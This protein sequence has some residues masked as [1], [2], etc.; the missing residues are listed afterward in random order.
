MNKKAFTLLELLATL[1]VIALIAVITI[2]VITNL[3][4]G[5]KDSMYVRSEETL[6]KA[7]Q[8]YLA[9]NPELYPVLI[10]D[11]TTIELEDLLA[12]KAVNKILDPSTK[13]EC[14]GYVTIKKVSASKS[15]YKPYI[16]CG[17]NYATTGYGESEVLPVITI[18]GSNPLSHPVLT[19]Y[20]DAGATALDQYSNN[21]TGDI[22][23]VN[24]VNSNIVGTY[25]VDY[26]VTDAENNT[27]NVSR[28]VN[29]VD[30]INP[31]ITVLGT[32]PVTINAGG[33]YVD[34]GATA[35]DNYS[36]NLTS[37]IQVTTN[38]T[39]A[40]AG[41]YTT[42]YTVS[43][44]SGNIATATRT[45]NV[46]ESDP[47]VIIFGTNGNA[48]Y[49]QSRSSTITATD[50]S[51]I[52]NA[53]L[54]YQWTTS[55]TAPSEVSFVTPYTNGQSVSSPAGVT[56]TYYLWAIAKDTGG[57]TTISRTNSFNLDN[58]IPVITLLGTTPVTHPVGTAYTDAGATASDNIDG[59]ITGSISTSSNVTPAIPGSYTVTYNVTD[60]SGNVAT[61]VTRTV[62][63][64]DPNP[65]TV[66]F[67]TNGNATYAQS[68]S[69]TVTVSDDTAVDNASLEYQWTTSTSAPTEV[70]FV[71]SFTNG[72]SISSPAGVT[73]GYYLWI[74]AKDTSANTTIT[75]SNIFNIDNTVP[76][77]AFGT[78][79][80][81]TYAQSGSTTVTT[82]DAHQGTVST[83][84]YQWTTSTTAPATG[85]FSVS[86]TSGNSISTPAGVTGDY[87]LWIKAVDGLG[88]ETI[89]RS[90][91]FR[92]DNTVPTV[93]FGTNGSE[94]Y[95]QSGSTTVTT[96]DAHQGTVATR[97]YQ[98]T[99]ST[100]AP[101]TGSF[102]VSFTSGNSI[103]TPAGVTGDYYLWIKAVDG[104]GNETITRSNRFRLDN[105]VPTVAFGTNG[106]ETY[107]QSRSTTVTTTDAH[108]GTVPTRQYQWTTS[109]TAP[110]TGSFS[111]SFT[112]GGTI[113][114]PVA[115]G[116]YYLWIKAVDGAGNENI[117]RS[118]RFRLDN[119]APVITLLGSTPVTISVG[120]S[121]TDAGATASDNINGNITASI[122]TNNPVNINVVGTYT[123]TYNVTDLSG[124][125][126]TQVT[127][128]VNVTDPN[129]PVITFGTNGNA[130]YAKTRSSTINVTDDTA[131]DNASL[132]YQW[133]TST[134]A[135]SEVSFSLTFTN[136]NSVSSPAGVTGT[137][138]L[139]ALAKD[140]GGNTTIERTN[141]FN[142]D[143]T[144]P[145]ITM[146]GSSPINHPVG[147]AYTD[148]GATA[149]DGID[150]NL[151]SSISTNNG[152]NINTLG[153]YSVTYNV[154][155]S[156]GNN[157]TQVTRTVNVVD[158]SIPTVAFG[159]NGN[160]TYAKS[161]STTAT[162]SDNIQVDTNTLEYQWTTST[163]AP[164]EVSFVTS[165]TNGQSINT[166]AGV[167]GGY[168]LWILAKDTSGNT[169]IDRSNVFNLDNTAPVITLL[170]TTPVTHPVGTAYSD[171]GATA[172]DNIDGNITGSISTSSNVTPA[173]PGSYTVTYNVTDASGNNATEVTR[174]VNVTDTT[175]PT[176]AFGTNGNAT[177]AQSRSTTVTVSDNVAVNASTLEYQWTTSTS[178]P[179]EVSFVTSFTNGQSINTPAGVTGGYYLW[180]LAKD[181]SGNTLI[182]R[183]NVFNLDNTAPVIT[184]SGSSPIDHNLGDTYTDAGATASDNIDGNLTSS[185]STNNGVNINTAGTYYVTY[186][187]TDSSGNA[188]TQVTRTVNVVAP[189]NIFTYTYTGAYETFTAPAAGTYLI[190]VWGASG[191]SS[192]TSGCTGG[193]GGYSKGEIT[194]S[195]G[196]SLYVYVGGAGSVAT[197]SGTTLGGWNGGGSVEGTNVEARRSG[198]G[199][200]ASDVRQGGTALSNR[201]IVAGGGG[202]SGS[203]Y[204]NYFGGFGGGTTGGNNH[205][206][207]GAGTSSAGGSVGG[208]LGTGGNGAATSRGGGGGGYYGGG[209]GATDYFGGGGGSS[210]LGSLSNSQTIAGNATMPNPAGGTMTGNSGNG[211]VIITKIS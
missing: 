61:Q 64:V 172:S 191:G 34:E 106:S 209:S 199:G 55:T 183:S 100:T 144:I 211:Y 102:S 35:L 9:L 165:F 137:Y 136:N 101:A 104:L 82:A 38:F 120:A 16:R 118:N 1:V 62:N 17:E 197:A 149:T 96:T 107:A 81:E 145:V 157:A 173:I 133:T 42:T 2:P 78:N 18:L 171:A 95:A 117:T 147:T 22:V 52:D 182:D 178:A 194:L 37:S 103:S 33:S 10:G 181:T 111:V 12:V 73:G 112:S 205:N 169:L 71:T 21:I 25:T 193:L 153:S 4:S 75:R 121:Y 88:N 206:G 26:S 51:G 91:R 187:V 154:S 45:I 170:G 116:D 134:T 167:T 177:Y 98:W 176:V 200:G 92:L 113:T 126:A 80:S 146:T 86:F 20:T 195:S 46:I 85:S 119:T 185:I 76:T 69:T 49:A 128:T 201:I 127:R 28:T 50:G 160:A 143:N 129:P 189:S 93:A 15:E 105:T 29:V 161:R 174:T 83:R 135:P 57:S 67:G 70:S 131:V 5:T 166:P 99:T 43:D 198:S 19:A 168:Y 204:S 56:G 23:T 11:I 163:S 130:T 192:I 151:T 97:Q 74:L 148:A 59:N 115:T 207:A 155:D 184:M 41:T 152:V 175:A 39:P 141:A 6:E 203:R 40:I 140:T 196:N 72:Q 8:N 179:T 180:I 164:T 79:G 53:S 123:V 158:N 110:A 84:Q 31:V 108:Q 139:W 60:S 114:T 32:N 87:Y 150:G 94:T 14:E 44:S 13:E 124:N 210:Y 3:I 122:V 48:T 186:N 142:L 188:A 125:A 24:N 156:S 90:N 30:T 208:A 190:E 77:V 7:A 89:T 65:P 47:P 132:K 138:Y 63:V 202:G 66:A 27:R 109:T 162:V 68:R 36:G 54:E 58:T 159:T